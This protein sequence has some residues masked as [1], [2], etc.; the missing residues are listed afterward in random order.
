MLLGKELGNDIDLE[1]LAKENDA[2]LLAFGANI[3]SKMGIEGENLD[4][5]FG[6]NELLEYE[7]FPSLEGKRVAVIRWW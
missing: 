4:G 2:V 7:N 1:E 3:S 6:A 5:V